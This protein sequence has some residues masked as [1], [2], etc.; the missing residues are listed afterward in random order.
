MS[1]AVLVMICL[2]TAGVGTAPPWVFSY[3]WITSAATPAVS[4]ADSLVPPN[5]RNAVGLPARLLQSPYIDVSVE[6][7]A[8]PSSPGATTSTV[9]PAESK[10]PELNE[11]MLLFR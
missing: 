8:Q 6:Q 11:L 4:G 7:S 10:P 2:T 1:L 9:P 5:A 3:A